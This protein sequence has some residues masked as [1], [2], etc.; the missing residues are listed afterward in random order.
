[1]PALAGASGAGRGAGNIDM[2]T[3]TPLSERP[4]V[5]LVGI[6]I[7]GREVLLN[8]FIT[9]DV[10]IGAICDCDRVRREDG[11]RRVDAYYAAHDDLKSLVGTCRAVADFREVIADPA[12]DAVCIATPDHWHA[13]IAVEAMKH[14]KDVYCEKPLTYTVDESVKVMKAQARYGRVFQTGSMQRSWREF[15]TAAMIVRNG[16]VG[17]IRFV[18]CNFGEGTDA[19][20]LGGPSQPH[21]YFSRPDNAEAEGAPNP[22]VDWN[23]WL[24][25][26]P[27]SP[28]SDQ[29]APRGVNAFYPMFWRFDDYFATGYCGDWGAHHL[30][31]AQWGL[32]MDRSGP[33]KVLCSDAPHSKNL[34]HGGRRQ[35]GMKFVFANGLVLN[36]NPFSTWGT[37]F[38]GTKGVVAVNRGKIAVWEGSGVEPD[39]AVRQALAA[40]DFPGMTLVAASV[41]KDY[42]KVAVQQADNALVTTLDRLDSRYSIDTLPL[43]LYK[44]PNQ[45]ANFITCMKTRQPTIAPAETGAR[46]AILCQLCNLSYVYDTG[47]DWNPATC[48]FAKGTGDRHWLRR[49]YCRNGWEVKV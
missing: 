21:R 41:G 33:V 17:D 34:L 46:T 22:D 4:Y 42:G 2:N 25:P 19:P 48:T 10:I 15:R 43:Q 9:R 20:L 5:A 7:Q 39:A 16:L 38:Y 12:I 14:G 1:M 27:Y 24:G 32:D 44:S 26:A 3:S 13:Y 45:I 37:I 18:D 23:L 31:I 8:E 11:V 47:F 36:H 28:Y 35:Q 49:D 30:D 29:C 40:A 6:G